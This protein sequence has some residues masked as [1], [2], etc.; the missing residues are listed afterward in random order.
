MIICTIKTSILLVSEI[1]PGQPSKHTPVSAALMNCADN[2][3]QT[4]Q[5]RQHSTVCKVQTTQYRQHTTDCKV[6]TAQYR[7]DR[8]FDTGQWAVC[9]QHGTVDTGLTEQYRLSKC[10]KRVPIF[11]QMFSELRHRPRFQVQLDLTD[12]VPKFISRQWPGYHDQARNDVI[13]HKTLTYDPAVKVPPKDY[14][15][16]NVSGP[17]WYKF[18]TR[19]IIPYMQQ[20]PPDVVLASG[21]QDPLTAAAVL[22]EEMTAKEQAPKHRT[23]CT[24]TDY[25]DESAQTDP[26]SPDYVIKPGVQPELLT[27]ATLSYGCGLPAGL[28]EVEMIERARAKRVWEATLP[29]LSD[30]TQHEKRKKMMEDMEHI[31]W[32][33]REQEIEKLQEARLAMLK[34]LLKQRE[35]HHQELNSKRLDRLWAKKQEVKDVKIKQIRNNHIKA[36]R[37]MTIERKTIEGGMHRRDIVSDYS[38][39]SSQVYAPLARIGVFLDRGSEQYV[40]K[41]RYLASYQGL[42]ELENALPDFVTQPRVKAPKPRVIPKQGYVRRKYRRERELAEIYELIKEQAKRCE[43]PPKPLRYLQKIEKPIPR[44]PTPT[45]NIPDHIEEEKELGIIFLQQLIRGR[46]VQNMM[47]EG[48]QKRLELIDELRSTHALQLAEQQTQKQEK[49]ATRALQRQR[50]LHEH[51]ESVID[52]VMSELEGESLGD[53]LDFL[54]K[55]LI[56]LQEERRIH[57]FAMLAERQRRIREAEESGWRQMEERRRREEDELF[58]QLVVALVGT[59]EVGCAS[60]SVG[61]TVDD[62]V[63]EGDDRDGRESSP[64]PGKRLRGG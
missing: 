21:R 38:D 46:A 63:G 33:L 24:Q 18:F 1:M 12:P 15:D 40:V 4:T 26:Y 62:K 31:E 2:G 35:E 23:I 25:R 61:G 52:K 39:Y 56:R 7:L 41:S 27:L 60:G 45:V 36:I 47:Y 43:E 59:E 10:M 30:V 16:Q 34:R 32:K 53:M 13:R 14:G 20:V 29:P 44:P 64:Q 48:K 37:K 9:R 22:E 51:K 58:K 3:D 28:A 11:K 49:L 42:L 57:A 55:E 54:S 8:T 19:P 50:R 6:Q 17:N 5:Y